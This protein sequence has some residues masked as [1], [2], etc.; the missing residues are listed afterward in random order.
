MTG[1]PLQVGEEV[2]LLCREL[3]EA[4]R[5]N[6]RLNEAITALNAEIHALIA[7]RDALKRQL[8]GG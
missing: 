7:E 4:R 8:A 5:L 2:E 6:Q 3:T 1:E